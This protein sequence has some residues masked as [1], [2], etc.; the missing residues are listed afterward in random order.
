MERPVTPRGAGCARPILIYDGD[1]NFCRFWIER[2]RLLTV[3]RL[4]YIELQ[5]PT[6]AERFPN[7]PRADLVKAVHLV[8]PDGNICQGAEAVF[9]SLA[10]N[11][12]WRWLLAAYRSLPGVKP[13]SER[14]YQYVAE[15]RTG[16]SAV[17]RIAL[18]GYPAPARYELTRNLFLR[19]LGTI[20][21]IAFLSLWYQVDGL[22]GRNG[23]LPAAEYVDAARQYF[24]GQQ[25]GWARYL[26]LPTWCWLSASDFCLHALCGL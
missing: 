1:C 14:L 20:Y 13:A 24:D 19:G 16:L 23:I 15:H 4:D 7:L 10:L 22:I 3:D 26:A 9:R 21:L 17:T 6:V 18:G 25:V 11:P 5:S 8:E 12:S 2:W